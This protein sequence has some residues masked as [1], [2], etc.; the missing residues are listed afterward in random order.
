VSKNITLIEPFFSGSHAAWAK[1]YALHSE[2]S[3]DIMGLSGNYWKWRM[4]GGAVTLARQFLEAPGSPDL[5]LVTDM[6]DLTTFLAL[7]RHK[8]ARLPVV[9]YFHENQI[10]YPWSTKDRDILQKRDHHYGFINYSS[11]LAAD[12]VLF[13]SSYHQTAFLHALPLFLKQFPDPNEL[14]TVATIETKSRVLHLGLDLKKFDHPDYQHARQD[15]PDQPPL[16]LWNHRWEYDKNP[17][18][19]FQALFKLDEQGLDFRVA[20]LG[21]HFRQQYPIFETAREILGD[22]IVHYG[23]ADTFA[24]YATWLHR[25][26]IIPM[27]SRQEFFGASL[28]EALYCG[29]YPVLPNRLT[30]PELIPYD[31]YPDIFYQGFDELVDKIAGA[32]DA[33]ETIRQQSL[34]HCVE[35]Y[36][37]QH[38]APVYDRIVS[39]L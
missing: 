2:H 33:I 13:N 35:P 30:Y 26:D 24:D 25:S 4:H 37:W 39:A 27:T 34:R 9:I 17:E 28:V 10:C 38:M 8:T 16:I 1:G 3:I 22:K 21:E 32:I 14:G 15:M 19:F 18:T 7:T 31:R 12:L 29:C 23:Y 6:L 11:A 20:I 5:L 36:S